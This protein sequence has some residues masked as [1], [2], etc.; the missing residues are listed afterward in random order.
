MDVMLATVLCSIA[1]VG[2]IELMSEMKYLDSLDGFGRKGAW[3]IDDRRAD[4]S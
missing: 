4:F 1:V 2:R 3:I